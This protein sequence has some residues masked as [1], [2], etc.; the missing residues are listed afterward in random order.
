MP[1]AQAQALYDCEAEDPEELSFAADDILVVLEEKGPD[2]FLMRDARN[3]TGL[4]PA[5]YVKLL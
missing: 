5:N 3:N 4:V 2:W 1:A